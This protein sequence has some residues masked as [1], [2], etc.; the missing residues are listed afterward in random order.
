MFFINFVIKDKWF[1]SRLLDLRKNMGVQGTLALT[2]LL[3]HHH[4]H[5]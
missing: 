4:A 5:Q 1:I 3:L 2:L